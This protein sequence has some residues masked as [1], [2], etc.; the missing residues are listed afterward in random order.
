MWIHR[1]HRIK[2]GVNVAANHISLG[3]G[4]ALIGHVHH[5]HPSFIQHHQHHEMAR[6][7][8][9]NR[10]IGQCIWLCLRIG[11]IFF[12]RIEAFGFVAHQ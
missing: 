6:C 10:G 8:I 4:T 7:A 2:R 9:T 1:H 12:K 3:L 5:L 11:N